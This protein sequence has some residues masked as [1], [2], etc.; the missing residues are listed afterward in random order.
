MLLIPDELLRSVSKPSS[1]STNLVKIRL[2]KRG[3]SY[4]TVL[5][6]HIISPI[7]AVI[8]NISKLGIIVAVGCVNSLTNDIINGPCRKV[9]TPILILAVDCKTLLIIELVSH[10]SDISDRRKRTIKII[11]WRIGLTNCYYASI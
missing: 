6:W 7:P 3:T 2:S 5:F 1:S 4:T 11:K 9:K 10:S 8:E